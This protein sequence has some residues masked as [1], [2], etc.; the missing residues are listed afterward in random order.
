MPWRSRFIAA[1][2]AVDRWQC[3]VDHRL[4]ERSGREILPGTG[5]DVFGV[6]GEYF[7]IGV[8]LDV[9][10]GCRP[11]FLVDEIDDVLLE[12]CRVLNAVLRRPEYRAQGSW[13]DRKRFEDVPVRNLEIVTVGVQEPLPRALGRNDRFGIKRAVFPFVRHFEEQQIGELLGVFDCPDAVVAQD[14]AIGPQLADK[15]A[16]FSHGSGVSIHRQAVCATLGGQTCM[17]RRLC[18]RKKARS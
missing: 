17:L 5:L 9:G 13:L 8:A 12:L 7:L 14:V 15:P 10:A 4:D 1:S 11:V 18:R 2:R 16:G 3:A 6:F